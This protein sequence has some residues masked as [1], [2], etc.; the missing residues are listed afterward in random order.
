M[1]EIVIRELFVG[2]VTGIDNQGPVFSDEK[3]ALEIASYISKRTKSPIWLADRS[4]MMEIR[5]KVLDCKQCRTIIALNKKKER[6]AK[7]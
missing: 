4:S 1:T 3:S 5:E 2:H 6:A 7:K